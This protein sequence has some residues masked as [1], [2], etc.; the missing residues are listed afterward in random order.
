MIVQGVLPQ[1]DPRLSTMWVLLGHSETGIFVPV[2][3]H[4]VESGGANRV[5]RYLDNGD[6]GIS[7]YTPARGMFN[8]G[9]DPSS[10]QAR[11]LPFE[12]HLF[13][14]VDDILLPDWRSRDWSD[15][16]VVNKIGEEMRRVQEQMDAEAYRHL[17]YLY[18]HGT[19]S[20]FAPTVSIDTVSYNGLEATF[21]VT[22]HD[23]DDDTLAYSFNYGDGHIGS[24]VTHKYVQDGHYLVTCT[25]T[26]NHGVS[27]TDWLFVTVEAPVSYLPYILK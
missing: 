25:V 21:S 2:W 1:E 13:D 6:D 15:E 22:T 20:N 5:P 16:A 26:D 14:V 24:D 3:L 18:D 8:A 7:I 17:K 23:P 4:G 11:S 12:E 27:Q 9:F 19:T 10:V